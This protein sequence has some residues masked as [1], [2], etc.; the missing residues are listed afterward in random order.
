ML[1]TAHALQRPTSDTASDS[2]NRK[3]MP[4]TDDA[5]IQ[6]SYALAEEYARAQL[7]FDSKA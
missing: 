7:F 3:G 4:V 5:M 1:A 6:E 2:K